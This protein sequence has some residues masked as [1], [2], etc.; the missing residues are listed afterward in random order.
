MSS[1][2]SRLTYDQCYIDEET[3]QSIKPGEYNLY[4]GQ[5]QHDNQCHSLDGPRNDRV[6]NSSENSKSTLGERT[7]LESKL[8]NRDEPASKCSESRTLS[9]K[10]KG[11]ASNLK[12][13][14]QCDEY[15][16]PQHSRLNEPIDNFRGLSTINLQL[17]YP[18]IDPKVSV[19]YGHNKTVLPEQNVN[20]RF[21][22]ST[23]LEA[24]DTYR[25]NLQ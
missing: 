5:N 13:H 23:R 25:K 21:G 24:K 1:H 15:L 7:E 4:Y 6:H 20:S 17:D 14:V 10:R 16:N 2:F 22:N 18:I 11:I 3:K 8:S 12:H 9:D 19:F